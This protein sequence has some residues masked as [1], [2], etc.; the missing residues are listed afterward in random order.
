MDY[1]VRHDG[2]LSR[3]IVRWRLPDSILVDVHL[4]L[5]A[6]LSRSPT[7]VL[8][9]DPTQFEGEGMN[10]RLV[11][12]DPANRLLEHIFLFQVFYHADEQTL[13]VTRGTHITAT[14]L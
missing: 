8:Y 10:Y 4:R 12:I 14:G 2:L 5:N 13:L 9:R 3:Q 6:D 1:K 11:L 7:S